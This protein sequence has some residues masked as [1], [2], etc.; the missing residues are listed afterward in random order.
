MRCNL[1]AW[2]IGVS[3]HV[4]QADS[5]SVIRLQVIYEKGCHLTTL[6]TSN[7]LITLC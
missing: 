5:Q 6:G 4:K 7:T 1:Y 2:A 3:V